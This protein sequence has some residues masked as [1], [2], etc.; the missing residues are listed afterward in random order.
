MELDAIEIDAFLADSVSVAD[1]KINVEGAGWDTI[2]TSGFPFRYS[3]LGIA[4]VLRVPWTA[5]NRMHQFGIRLI[6]LDGKFL[7]LADAPPGLDLPGGKAYELQG[8]FNVG[9]PPALSPGESQL[10]P[11]AVNIDDIVFPAATTYSIVISIDES[12]VRRLTIRV[13][14]AP[15]T[16]PS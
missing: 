3:R 14:S 9:R 5:T 4:F 7:P 15:V 16:T 1:N 10:I 11:V 12:E 6:D 8:Q 13:Q 2:V